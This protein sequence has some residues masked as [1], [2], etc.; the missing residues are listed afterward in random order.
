MISALIL[1]S[2][3]TQVTVCECIIVYLNII[4]FDCVTIT[5]SGLQ[6]SVTPS[7]N[8]TT[9]QSAVFSCTVDVAVPISWIINETSSINIAV[10]QSYISSY[11]IVADGL[12]TQDTT[13]TI[14]GDPVL[15]GTVVQCSAVEI[16]NNELT[17]YEV[18]SDTLYIQGMGQLLYVM[19]SSLSDRST[20]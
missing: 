8:I 4:S 11:G 17:Y 19:C 15:N 6:I 5:T 12:D 7:P 13:L 14:P 1:L 10:F 16:M 9:L 18:D 3:V 2:T 20:S